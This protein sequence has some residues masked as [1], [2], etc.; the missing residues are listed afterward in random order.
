MNE[1]LKLGLI[2]FIITAV[3][4][5]VLAVSNNIT[6][7]KI[8]EADRIKDES[9]KREILP[10]GDEFRP[11]DENKLKEIQSI[12]SNILEIYEGYSGSDLIGYTVKAKTNG[13]GGEI[14]FMTGISIEGK[15]MG[16]KI[17][18][19]GETPGLGANAEKPYFSESFKNKSV[20]KELIAVKKHEGD[21]EVQALTSATIT[22]TAVVSEVNVV[23]EIYNSKL[24]N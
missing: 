5:S 11:L 22:T 10:D 4:A 3:S 7:P 8:A 2:L 14:E 6:A 23:R 18:N 20:E 21:N 12:D 19:H 1:T 24:A 13:Y 15:I 17:L 16:I 9:A